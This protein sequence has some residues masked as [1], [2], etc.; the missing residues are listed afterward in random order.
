MVGHLILNV[1]CSVQ[2]LLVSLPAQPQL[3]HVNEGTDTLK[4]FISRQTPSVF[5]SPAGHFFFIVVDW[6][7]CIIIWRV[8][9]K[10]TCVMLLYNLGGQKELKQVN[11][12]YMRPIKSTV[13]LNK[14]SN[15]LSEA[16]SRLAGPSE[17]IVKQSKS[18]DCIY[19]RNK[20]KR[21]W[22]Y[23]C[24]VGSIIINTFLSLPITI[25]T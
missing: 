7:Y 19:Q 10:V 3:Y 4:R 18:S 23:F 16:N 25:W 14:C 5:F 24:S 8:F 12:S 17:L 22:K 21:M 1:P 15:L 20:T 2:S 13:T 6:I 11:Q 9:V